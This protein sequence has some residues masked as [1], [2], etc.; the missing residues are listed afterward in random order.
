MRRNAFIWYD[1]MKWHDILWFGFGWNDDWHD[2]VWYNCLWYGLKS[3]GMF[4]YE[5]IWFDDLIRFA[6]DVS[7]L[8]FCVFLKVAMN[9]NCNFTI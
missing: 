4:W 8:D 7:L 5:G 9:D 2:L 6:I 3:F 1:L